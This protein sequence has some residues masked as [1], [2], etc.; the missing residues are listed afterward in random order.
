MPFHFCQDELVALE[1]LL[2]ALPFVGIAVV[3]VRA[4]WRTR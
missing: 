1:A 2:G 4:W 3:R